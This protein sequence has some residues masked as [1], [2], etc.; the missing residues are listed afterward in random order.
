[1]S[2]LR[3]V[4]RDRGY[5]AT[6]QRVMVWDALDGHLSA[7]Q[8]H[9]AIASADVNLSTVY[10]T[11]ELFVTEGLVRRVVLPDGLRRYERVGDEHHH[12]VC[13]GCGVVEHVCGQHVKAVERHLVQRHGFEVDR[14]V[15]TAY[16]RCGTCSG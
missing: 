15:M 9:A 3:A 2:D 5:R 14:I 4:L 11:L 1:M 8:I 16:G 7:E 6:P 10:R 12:L 13:I